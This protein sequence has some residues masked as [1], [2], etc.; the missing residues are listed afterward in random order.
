MKLI[1]VETKKCRRTY[2]FF[3]FTECNNLYYSTTPVILY[4]KPIK[5]KTLIHLIY[6][7]INILIFTRKKYMEKNQIS[8]T[9]MFSSL[10]C[11]QCKIKT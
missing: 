2:H 3:V 11:V 9:F 4:L 6:L 1:T 7:Y 8:S 5:K 10:K